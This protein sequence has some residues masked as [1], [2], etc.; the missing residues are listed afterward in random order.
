M[1]CAAWLG[2]CQGQP[3]AGCP[4]LTSNPAVGLPPYWMKYTKVSGGT[5][6]DLPGEAIGFQK[7][8]TPGTKEIRMA[9]V[10]EGLGHEY[11]SNGRVDPADPDGKKL[12][13]FAKFPFA[14]EA[15]LT[16]SAS[17]FEHPAQNFES[18]PDELLP[19]GG[20]DVPG[21]PALSRKYEFQNLK[22]LAT[23]NAPGTVFT[24]EVKLT[25]DTCTATMKAIGLWP[26]IGCDP[27]N[28]DPKRNNYNVDCD[29]KTDVDA[30]HIVGSGINP[31]FA[32]EGKPVTCGAAGYCEVQLTF[33]EISK[34]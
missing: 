33:D 9:Y 18:V 29:P 13:G 8:N 27:A 34:L 24:A 1:A 30:G 14:P 22:F 19:D 25:E 31:T 16:C 12:L 20:V 17:Q 4:V 11:H 26:Q 21:S 7:Y 23:V 15:D 28:N 5:C 10:F 32:P 3:S 6:G 2:A